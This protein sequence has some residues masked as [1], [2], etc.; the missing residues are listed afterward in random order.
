MCTGT[1]GT[2]LSWFVAQHSLLGARWSFFIPVGGWL[3][4]WLAGGWAA[5]RVSNRRAALVA[6]VVLAA[7][8]RLAAA[9]GTTPSI[10]NDLY[11]YGWDAHVQLSG[12]DPYRY[13]PAAPQ[14][15]HL[16]T[17]PFFPTP[18]GCAQIGKRPDCTTLNRP[19]ARTI[20][21]PVAE[22]WFDLVALV[23]PGRGVRQ[24]QLAGAAVDMAAIGLMIVGLTRLGRD[25]RDVAWYALSPVPVIEF[26]G[27]GHVDGLGLLLLLAALLALERRRQALAGLF[28]G[29]AT[30][31]KLYPGLA[32]VACWR[33]GRWPLVATAAGVC[34]V[35]YAP[36]IAAV[37]ARVVG[38]LPGYLRE[39][40]YANAARFLLIGVLPVPGQVVTAVAV[41]ALAAAAVWVVRTD[42][43][44]A[45]GVAVLLAAAVF[46]TSPVQPWYAVGLAGVG[47]VAGSPW[48]I[49]PALLAEIYYAAV[50]LD[51]P[52]QVA[53]GRICYGA[54]LVA[55]LT[56]VISARL[57]R[58][59]TKQSN[60]LVKDGLVEA[61]Q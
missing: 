30:M 23:A 15:Q 44:P 43:A 24:W 52:H 19:A 32:A 39:E 20:Y 16:R 13:P 37:G 42:L 11:R 35:A 55:V 28:I 31:V 27:N 17:P 50:V 45:A 40:H 61:W 1:V 8:A 41:L 60:S 4:A 10:S 54:A 38:Y 56:A 36:H 3:L 6:I 47:M 46:V 58:I 33:K 2:A 9:S 34:A 59:R 25:P 48:L 5:V 49:T 12:I 53:V 57:V 21:P 22:A 7:A 14:Q 26:A 18:A 29:M 51:D